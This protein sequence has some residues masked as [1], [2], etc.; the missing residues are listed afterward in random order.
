[1][2]VIIYGIGKY[3]SEI[4]N[5]PNSLEIEII[6]NAVG[7]IGFA[8]TN[9]SLF[10]KEII[11]DG[12]KFNVKSIF[13]FDKKDFEGILI[14]TE[15]YFDEISSFLLEHGYM[16]KE[17][18][19]IENIKK[20][21]FDKLYYIEHFKGKLG[22]EIGGPTELFSYIYNQCAACDN[23][24]FSSH[25]VWWKNDTNDFRY[26]NK[27]MGDVFITEATDM[28]QIEGERYDFIL[29]SNNLEHTANPLKALK[30]FSRVVKKEGIVLILVPIKEKI[31]DHNRDYTTFEHLLEDYYNDT[32]ED[33]LS[34]LQEIIMQHDYT[35]DS[36]CGGREKFIERAKKNIENRCLHH[37]VF[38][39]QCLRKSFLF[40]GLKV[41]AF[42]RLTNNW[43]IIGQ[44]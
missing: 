13:D 31:F 16:E 38:E 6:K 17:I 43:M 23:V 30:E 20:L 8:D 40:V 1:M 25:T 39:E 36:Q 4:F 18:F 35:M 7:I 19:L 10:G 27:K 41:I 28:Y 2:R 15:K 12:K 14:T 26:K 42:G 3:Y 37:H 24:N 34:H 11:Y 29:S 44:K 5:N 21:Y 33:D 32:G 22:L 9:R